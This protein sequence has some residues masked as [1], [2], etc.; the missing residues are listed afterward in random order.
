MREIT[1]IESPMFTEE[2]ILDGTPYR[3][4]FKWNTRGEFWSL[5]IKSAD[6]TI[7][8][9]FKIVLNYEIIS[10]F[11]DRNLPPG[12]I[13]AIDTTG[14]NNVIGRNDFTADRQIKIVYVEKNELETI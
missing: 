7:Y 14:N 10:D 11:P 12:Q 1:F 6:N 9:T 2:I 3:F 5:I 13:Y 8:G 4:S